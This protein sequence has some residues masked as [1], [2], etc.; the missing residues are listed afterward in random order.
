MWWARLN[1]RGQSRDGVVLKLA[2]NSPG[3]NDKA[4]SKAVIITGSE[5]PHGA[6]ASS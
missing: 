3:F 6:C 4:K 2:N 5:S 1:L